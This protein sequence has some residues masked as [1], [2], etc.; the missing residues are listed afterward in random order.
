M[1]DTFNI[2]VLVLVRLSIQIIFYYCNK[3]IFFS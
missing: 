3:V 1:F 2:P